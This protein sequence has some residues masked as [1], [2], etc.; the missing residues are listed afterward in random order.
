M[1]V[2]GDAVARQAQQ[3]LRID[4]AFPFRGALEVAELHAAETGRYPQ[5]GAIAWN[6]RRATVTLAFPTGQ[7]V[8]YISSMED[9]GR[10][11]CTGRNGKIAWGGASGTGRS[12]FGPN[13]TDSSA[14]LYLDE[15][16]D[17]MVEEHMQVHMNMLFGA[18]PTGTAKHY[19]LYRFKRISD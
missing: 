11:V 19:A 17:L 7:P 12:E 15:H 4:Y 18:I 16:G 6:D 5:S 1:L 10:F 14:A 2:D 8:E 9:K 13:S 3:S